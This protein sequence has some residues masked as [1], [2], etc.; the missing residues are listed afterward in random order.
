[1]GL[2]K[3]IQRALVYGQ[4]IAR[5][6]EEL[7]Q[8]LSMTCFG[9]NLNKIDWPSA[10]KLVVPLLEPSVLDEIIEDYILFE[11]RLECVAEHA[12]HVWR[13]FEENDRNNIMGN[14]IR[15]LIEHN[16]YN[17]QDGSIRRQRGEALASMLDT[18]E[19]HEFIDGY[20]NKNGYP[21]ASQIHRNICFLFE[22]NYFKD[23]KSH[24]AFLREIAEFNK[25]EVKEIVL[26]ILEHNK[27]RNN[28]LH[29]LPISEYSLIS[30]ELKIE[31]ILGMQGNKLLHKYANDP[32]LIGGIVRS[33]EP[34]IP[35]DRDG[36]RIREDKIKRLPNGI[37][38]LLRDD[39]QKFL[40]KQNQLVGKV[41]NYAPYEFIV[42]IDG[43]IVPDVISLFEV[44]EKER[45]GKVMTMIQDVLT[46][47]KWCEKKRNFT[48]ILKRTDIANFLHNS[49]CSGKEVEYIRDLA[50]HRPDKIEQELAVLHA[51]PDYQNEIYDF[52]INK[53]EHETDEF[54]LLLERKD[55]YELLGKDV[56]KKDLRLDIFNQIK[57]I[58]KV[59]AEQGEKIIPPIVSYLKTE[60]PAKLDFILECTKK[61]KN[62]LE[63]VK[64]GKISLKEIEDTT[65]FIGEQGFVQTP[66][67][68]AELY[69][70]ID[71]DRENKEKT[72]EEWKQTLTSFS[73]GNFDATNELHRNLEYTR[74]RQFVDHEKVKKYIKNHFTYE[75][76]EL[77]FVSPSAQEQTLSDQDAFEVA[78]VAHEAQKLY[79]FI[80]QVKEHADKQG[81][82][83]VVVPN[84]SYGY[85]PI[86]PLVS[87][88]EAEG[89][90]VLIGCKVGSTE[91]H[92]NKEVMNS[93][94]FN[95]RRRKFMEEQPVI[96]VVDGTQHLVDRGTED[97]AARYPD[98]Y[99][100]Y[101]NQT[102]AMNDARG[103]KQQEYIC[104]GK[105]EEDLVKLRASEEFQQAVHVYKGLTGDSG[106][107]PYKFALWNTAEIPLIIRNYPQKLAKIL[108][109]TPY[110]IQG[111][112]MI[113]CNVGVLDE[114]LPQE[115]KQ[116]YP[117]QTHIPAYYDDSG[118]IIAFDYG[119]D[120][121]GL[122]YLNRLETKVKE[123]F[124]TQ[125]G[126]REV[127]LDLA[128]AIMQYLSKARRDA[129]E[130][131]CA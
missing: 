73:K 77:I 27:K 84:F 53:K 67:L 28:G 76:Y 38:N 15:S 17:I 70:T 78:C 5:T 97:T 69:H 71:Q 112:T 55:I 25:K 126:S 45:S 34:Y 87:H 104:V 62:I 8:T 130:E 11:K 50:L 111:P 30:A 119:F 66:Y 24:S 10:G 9:P 83:V 88:L 128:P 37:E 68:V 26:K 21:I 35:S 42:A 94:L 91:S 60:D 58:V 72:I 116:Q 56:Q 118:R 75:D 90:E 41:N 127:S 102:I 122:R 31:E 74:F 129:V 80:L 131:I 89:I 20:Y 63:K 109:V 81:R 110:Q 103:F 6:G 86:A 107:E 92:N 124:E 12:H 82:N 120:K 117:G 59:Y 47:S 51:Y 113:F 46:N 57:R 105:T 22:H 79:D 44:Y 40:R 96:I 43:I 106:K 115:L 108:P 18:P 64:A 39:V 85:L 19:F 52:L 48:K 4:E 65:T 98:A 93:R 54:V 49:T 125:N 95:G 13:N 3:I 101:L 99:Q 121:F 114:Q 2:K 36:N 61:R 23:K 32:E 16:V 1:M 14:T 7:V 33:I 123:A 100:G 29:S